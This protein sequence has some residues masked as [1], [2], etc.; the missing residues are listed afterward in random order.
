MQIISQTIFGKSLESVTVD[1]VREFCKKQIREGINLDYKKDLSSTKK[2]LKT[3]ASFANTRG[4]WIIVGVDDKDDKPI[5]PATGFPFVEHLPLTITNIVLSDMWPSTIPVTHVCEPDNNGNT[6]LILYVPESPEAPH[7]IFN[8]RELYIRV[9]DRSDQGD[10]ERFATSDE[11]EWLR[12]KREKST[13][14]RE[15]MRN[16][17]HS[18]FYE[19]DWR[20]EFDNRPRGI[21]STVFTPPKQ[22]R[23]TAGMLNLTISPLFP[24]QALFEVPQTYDLLADKAVNDY[25]RTSDRYPIFLEHRQVFQSGSY[26]YGTLDEN[27]KYFTGLDVNGMLMAKET[28]LFEPDIPDENS[29]LP[30]YYV[31]LSRIGARLD[32][33]LSLAAAIYDSIGFVGNVHFDVYL[34]GESWMKMQFPQNVDMSRVYKSPTGEFSWQ[35]DF[36]VSD[37]VNE[38]ERLEL[39]KSI[40]QSLMYSFGW[41]D[42][43]WNILNSYYKSVDRYQNL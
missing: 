19:C 27:R 33:F 5:L 4:G 18:I 11:W 31:E 8:K 28:V 24:T 25:Y 40:V 2:I 38:K 7:W 32:Q 36:L 3:I 37:I 10:W 9:S 22:D 12:N 43:N 13:S 17:L 14:L 41:K 21:A 23:E 20:H 30:T 15:D 16:D 29:T 1:D 35:A 34:H 26:M 39:I 6:F 42:F